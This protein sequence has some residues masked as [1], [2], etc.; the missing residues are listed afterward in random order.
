MSISL[1][2]AVV[3]AADSRKALVIGGTGFMGHHTVEALL[4]AGIKVD[5]LSDGHSPNP[6]PRLVNETICDVHATCLGEK[7]REG[8]WDLVVDFPVFTPH[9]ISTFLAHANWIRH[10]IFPSSDD[11]YMVCNRSIFKYGPSGGVLEESA[12]RLD[13]KTKQSQLDQWDDYGNNKKLLEENLANSSLNFT[14]L[15]LPDVWG[16]YESTG[17][18]V[19][20]LRA[21]EKGISIGTGIHSYNPVFQESI[22]GATFVPGFVFA[23]DVAQMVVLLLQ[24]GPQKRPVN[25]AV[26]ERPTFIELVTQIHAILKSVSGDMPVG[27]LTFSAEKGVPLLSTDIG[28]LDISRARSLGFTPT[29]WLQGWKETVLAL[30]N[31]SRNDSLAAGELAKCRKHC[32]MICFCEPT[33]ASI[34]V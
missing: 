13:N 7:L 18:F 8:P 12:V 28:P 16:P 14:A 33:D 5:I 34:Y 21:L 24:S 6:W 10:Y 1:A 29:P 20:F 26:S 32:D 23:R 22:S 11:V 27:P 2:A 30:V 4:H 17:R 31:A 19:T 15:R 3:D 25:V 9:D